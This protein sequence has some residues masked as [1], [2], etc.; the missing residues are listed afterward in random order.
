MIKKS[1]R[2]CSIINRKERPVRLILLFSASVSILAVF[3]I[4]AYIFKESFPAIREFGFRHMLFSTQWSPDVIEPAKGTYG[5]L[6]FINGTIITTFLATLIGAP[7]AVCTAIYVNQMAPRS[8]RNIINRGIEILAGIPS[9]IIGWFGITMMVA[10]LRNISGTSGY[11]ILAAGLV[12]A[13]MSMPTITAISTDAL[14]A[15]PP[16][17]NEAS[18][19]LGATRWQTIYRALVP[20]ARRG[21]LVAVI[22][23]VGRAVGET[24]AVQMV[25]GNAEQ[26]A[27]G[28]FK[29][30]STLT[31]R[32]VTDIGESHG[33]F[34]SVV[35]VE[36]LVLLVFAMGL[37][38]L[39]RLVTRER[40]S[41]EGKADIEC[42]T[43]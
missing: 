6:A 30:T 14:K 34:R 16:E 26:I 9:V 8:I 40:K 18:L 11:G 7:L 31:S 17:L 33:L 20:A 36:G 22:L 41:R 13:I 29:P 12:L 24:M 5:L 32:I 15:L 19:A 37:I 28:L 38:L 27:W 4:F 3:F 43:G 1:K 42:E 39:I 35:Y 25:I 2:L 10:G 21:I 23:G